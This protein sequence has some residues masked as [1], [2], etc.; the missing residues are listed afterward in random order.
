MGLAVI[1]I[2]QMR[3]QRQ[4]GS[5]GTMTLRGVWGKH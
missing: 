3:K 2:V 5:D 1:S 4:T